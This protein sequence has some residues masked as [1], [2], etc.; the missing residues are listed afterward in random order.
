M[1]DWSIITYDDLKSMKFESVDPEE[2]CIK[3]SFSRENV[4]AFRATPGQLEVLRN[5]EEQNLLEL[6]KMIHKY[7]RDKNIDEANIY[8]KASSDCA[9]TES[10][11]RKVINGQRKP[12]IEF[13]SLISV[14]LGLTIDQATELFDLIGHTPFNK[15]NLFD[16]I[17]YIALRDRDSIYTYI[18][19]LKEAGIKLHSL[20]GQC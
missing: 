3:K 1:I 19:Q 8:Q 4:G 14:G 11:I 20:A 13:I 10:Q 18:Q 5:T 9:I 7:L 2:A 12:T 15:N 17:T 16:S 6:R